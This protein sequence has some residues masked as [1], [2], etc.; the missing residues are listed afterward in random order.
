MHRIAE[1]RVDNEAVFRDIFNQYQYPLYKFLYQKIDSDFYAREIV[2]LTFI[3]LWKYRHQ[4]DPDLDIAIQLFR[5][6]KTTLVDEIRKIEA[7]ERFYRSL[8]AAD[9]VVVNDVAQ[10]VQY[11]ETR[12][13]LFHL[14]EQLPPK[15]KEVFELSRIYCRSN[16]EIAQI[17]SLSPKTVENHITLALRFIRPFFYFMIIFYNLAA[18]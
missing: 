3:K 11:N 1:L 5:I 8:P 15:R 9:A 2:Q 10:T 13:R 14:M 17:L 7:R 16:R 18:I 4:L 6:A 12:A